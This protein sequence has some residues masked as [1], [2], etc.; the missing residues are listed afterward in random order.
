MFNTN[1]YYL[2]NQRRLQ[3]LNDRI[4]DRNIPS[5]ELQANF[6]PRP[7]KTRQI[8]F[9]ARDCH[10]RPEDKE[11]IKVQPVYNIHQQFNPGQ[12]APYSGYAT[13]VDQENRLK[14]IYMS[15][16]K[17]CAQTEY[18]PSSMSDLYVN[19]NVDRASLQKQRE[20]ND[21]LGY[22]SLLFMEPEFDHTRSRQDCLET[23][24]GTELFYNH[25]RQQLLELPVSSNPQSHLQQTLLSAPAPPS[26]PTYS[27]N[28][29]Q[30]QQQH[31]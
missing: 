7:V 5:Q 9:P 31:N 20:I 12:S 16:Q 27:Q 26:S 13:F 1:G 10:R 3:E 21:D 23:R 28:N 29:Q 17:W 19:R 22:H 30:Q 4:Y 11:T 24:L 8:L 14:N 25:T 18:V 6:D 15:N 2:C